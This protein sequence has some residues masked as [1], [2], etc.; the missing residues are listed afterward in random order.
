[1]TRS[2]AR[3]A[4]ALEGQRQTNV[5]PPVLE[6]WEGIDQRIIKYAEKCMR[7]FANTAAIGIERRLSETEEHWII[8]C[9]E[10]H[11]G[12]RTFTVVNDKTKRPR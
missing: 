3:V 9:F 7:Y 6:S 5:E 10:V 1:M 11:D 4:R 12:A 2:H 8:W